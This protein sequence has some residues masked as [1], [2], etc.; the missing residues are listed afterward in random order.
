MTVLVLTAS[1]QAWSNMPQA[2]WT[3]NAI[4]DFFSPPDHKAVWRVPLC[5][6]RPSDLQIKDWI[7]RVLFLCD[8]KADLWK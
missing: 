5:A 2:L 6:L 4:C 1:P 8:F 7:L 3:F